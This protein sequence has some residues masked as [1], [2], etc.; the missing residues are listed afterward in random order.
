MIKVG[1]VVF[2]ENNDTEFAQ[3][4]KEDM[5]SLIHVCLDVQVVLSL[6]LIKR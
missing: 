6:F 4:E 3:E 1:P 2:T 5:T